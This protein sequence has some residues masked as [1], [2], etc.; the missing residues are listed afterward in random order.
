MSNF[1]DIA[2]NRSYFLKD[3]SKVDEFKCKFKY[4]SECNYMVK[5]EELFSSHKVVIYTKSNHNNHKRLKPE[6]GLENDL[7]SKF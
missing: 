5:F 7:K 4:L 3:G 2:K 6:F 1:K